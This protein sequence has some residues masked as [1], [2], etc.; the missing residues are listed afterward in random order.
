MIDKE[1]A[2]LRR[3]LQPDKHNI[4]MLR[5]RYVNEKRETIAEFSTPFFLLGEAEAEMYL[6]IFRRVLSGGMG[7]NLIDIAFSNGQVG[8]AEEHLRLTALRDSALKD[9]DAVKAFFDAAAEGLPNEGNHLILL[10]SDTY[11]VPRKHRDEGGDS[12]GEESTSIFRYILSAVCP[13]KEARTSLAYD[14]GDKGFHARSC[15]WNVS[16]PEMGFLFPCFDNRQTNIYNALYYVKNAADSHEAFADALFKTELP[17]PAAEQKEA[18][19]GMLGRTLG[20]ECRLD[21]VQAI[22]DDIASRIEEHKLT[23]STEPLTISKFDVKNVLESCGVSEEKV[24]DFTASYD[25]CY[26][27]GADLPPRNIVEPKQMEVRTPDVVIK[28]NPER[29]DLIETRVIGGVKYVL[30]R[31]DEDVTVNG[32]SIAINE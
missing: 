20:E 6:A 12:G 23:K 10:M 28:V 5:G 24:S 27:V 25:D 29:G 30:I 2:E 21:V 22:H 14:A 19:E 13:V 8:A 17:M 18:F 11:D 1:T 32:V 3:R 7:R 26:G 31:A 15:I 16:S 4:T 9:E